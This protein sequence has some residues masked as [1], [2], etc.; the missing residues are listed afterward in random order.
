MGLKNET[1]VSN[2]H[3]NGKTRNI[4]GIDGSLSGMSTELICDIPHV[5][6]AYFNKMRSGLYCPGKSVLSWV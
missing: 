1:L 2:I 3:P 6:V 5:G 4:S